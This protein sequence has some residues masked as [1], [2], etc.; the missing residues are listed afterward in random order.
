MDDQQSFISEA[1]LRT[2]FNKFDEDG[3]GSITEDELRNAMRVL[4]VRCTPNSARKVLRTIDKDCNGTVEWHEFKEFFGRVSNPEELKM[5][6]SKQN[7]RFFEYKLL[8]EGDPSF[9]KT[10]G[11]PPSISPNR[12]LEGHNGDVEKVVWLSPTEIISGSIDGGIFVWDCNLDPKLAAKKPIKKLVTDEKNAL[13]CMAVSSDNKKLLA[14]LGSKTSNLFLWNLEEEKIQASLEGQVEPVYSC[15]IGA[16]A[17]TAASGSKA[18]AMCVHDLLAT[19]LSAFWKGH[20]NVVY[21]V[22]FESSGRQLCSASADGTVKIFDTRGVG[23]HKKAA[24]VIED[25]AASGI[26]YQALWRGDREIISCGDDYCIKRWDV[27]RLEDGPITSYFGHTSAVR[28]ICISPDGR[29]LVSGTNSGSARVWLIDELG[30]ITESRHE[31]ERVI[32][33]LESRRA[34][35]EDQLSDGSLESP[36]ELR[37]V[38]RTIEEQKKAA[39]K[40]QQAQHERSMLGCTQARLSLDGSAMPI[41]SI[42]WADLGDG[43]ARLVTGS[44]DQQVRVYDFETEPLSIIEAWS[45]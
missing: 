2:I 37:E 25:A 27:R 43:K 26:V 16:G 9:P 35:L 29:F 11:M 18:G 30:L 13:Y 38:I 41:S 24:L 17:L 23:E 34:T 8:V 4:G 7:Q 39:A 14:G 40:W 6:I 19:K 3:S 20:E 32:R 15:A 42:S 36:D 31:A 44:R 5:L 22:D 21:S 28:S 33:Q 10:F 45:K 12:K 1:E